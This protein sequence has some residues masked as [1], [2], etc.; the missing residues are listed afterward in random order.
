MN[1][2]EEEY[3][4][5]IKSKASDSVRIAEPETTSGINPEVE[6]TEGQVT[7]KVHSPI[8]GPLDSDSVTQ[9]QAFEEEPNATGPL[10]VAS[11]SSIS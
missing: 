5:Q 6:Q 10:L 11:T 1:Q 7:A 9:W 3:Q 2:E 8:Q 4:I